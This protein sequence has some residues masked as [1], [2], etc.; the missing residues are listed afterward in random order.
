[1]TSVR[2]KSVDVLKLHNSCYTDF[3]KKGKIFFK[4]WL[5]LTKS[6]SGISS[7]N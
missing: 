1:M 3:V 5:L 6:G 2:N 4:I 7:L